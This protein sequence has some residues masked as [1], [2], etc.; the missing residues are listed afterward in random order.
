MSIS[1]DKYRDFVE[2]GVMLDEKASSDPTRERLMLAAMGLAGESVELFK[3]T[4]DDVPIHLDSVLKETGDV[5]WYLVLMVNTLMVNTDRWTDVYRYWPGPDPVSTTVI[6]CGT[7]CDTIKKVAFHATK[8]ALY[9]GFNALLGY[10]FLD[11]TNIASSYG[12]SIEYV[13]EANVRK[14]CDRYPDTY[15]KAEDWLG[16]R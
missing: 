11:L 2:C 6:H 12:F 5:L 14:L 4:R 16:G 10:V 9:E 1:L 3:A 8:D 13:M 15:G 7:I